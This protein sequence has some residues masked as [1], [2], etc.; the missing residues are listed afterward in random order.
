[1]TMSETGLD[2][3]SIARSSLEAA[4]RLND[5]EVLLVAFDKLEPTPF[6]NCIL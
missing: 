1:M 6:S 4:I 5:I 2:F 3:N